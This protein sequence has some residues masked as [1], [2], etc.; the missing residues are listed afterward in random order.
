MTLNTTNFAFALKE[1]YPDDVMKDMT[2]DDRPLLAMLA[3]DEK[4]GGK[5]ITVPV[6]YGNPQGRSASLSTAITNKG[7]T[8]GVEFSLTRVSD[9]AVASIDRET[10]L[11]SETDE[12]AFAEAVETEMDGTINNCA[13]S[14]AKALYRDGNG[15]LGVVA[16]GGLTSA[17]PMVIT[18]ADINDIVNFEYG[19]V[20]EADN[21]ADGSSLKTTPATITIAGMDEDAGTIT[22]DFDN[23]GPTTNWAAADYLFQD[24]DGGNM[25]S[26]LAAWLP[27][28][29]PG[30][31]AFFGVDRTTSVTRLGGVRVSGTGMPVEQALLK[32]AARVTRQKGKPDIAFINPVQYYEL[33]VSLGSKVQYVKQGVTADVF[34]SGV[35]IHGPKGPIEVYPDAWCP[36]SVGYVLTKKSWKLYSL[37]QCPHVFDMDNAQKLLRETTAD[38]YELRVGYYAQLGCNAPG[39]NARVSFDAADFS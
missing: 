25:L 14:L 18:L 15:A 2:F 29:A 27:S 34:F 36:S 1:M 26:G 6:V 16:T 22:T 8:A 33:V 24:G 12:M 39:W 9:Y 13:N 17:N 3:K 35:I 32:A 19:M 4:A 28:S 21:T 31:T 10:M 23:S 7:N 5:T 30:A 11:A 38:A 20:I 37:K